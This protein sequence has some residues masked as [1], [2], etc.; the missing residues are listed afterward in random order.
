MGHEIRSGGQGAGAG[1][2]MNVGVFSPGIN[3]ET[4]LAFTGA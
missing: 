4:S 1:L 2:A 3:T